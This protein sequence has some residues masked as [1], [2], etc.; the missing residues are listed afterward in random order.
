MSSFRVFLTFVKPYWKLVLVTVVIGMIKFGIPLTMPVL[1]KYVVDDLLLAPLPA[2][3]KTERL[4][5]AM[6]AAFALF[7]VVRAPV[8]YYRQY[9]AQLTTSRILYDMRNK[10]YAHIQKLSLRYYHNHKTGE[11]ISRMINDAEA[12][13]SIVETGMMNVWLDL[14]TLTIAMGFMFYMDAELTLVAIAVLPFYALSVKRMYRKLKA[15][16]KSRSQALAEMQGFV[17]ERVNGMP[18][19]KSFTL[20]RT[21]MDNFDRRNRNFLQRALSL[22]RWNALTNAIINTLTDLSPLLVLLYGGYQVIHGRL[23]MGAFMA[24]FA[25]LDRLFTPLRRIVNS[26]TELTQASASL[27]RVVELMRE[28]YDIQDAPGAVPIRG[29]VPGG[30]EFDRVRFRYDT[31]DRWVLNDLSLTIRPGQTI[32]LVGMSG[33]GKSSLISLIPR[34]YDVQEGAIRLDGRDIRSLTLHS[35]RSQIGMVLQDNILFS[36]SVRDNILFG[37]PSASDE[38]IERAARAANAHD[39]IERLPAGYATEIGERGVKLSGGQKQRIA[40][41]RVFLKNPRIL[42]LDEATSA[43]DLESEH[44]IQESLEQLAKDRTTL[45]VAHRLSTI[46]HADQIV[47]IEDGRIVEQGTHEALM[48]RDGAYARL[49]NVQHLGGAPAQMT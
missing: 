21:E 44:L 27:E 8:E 9:F 18:V 46:T 10:L 15:F 26:S 7:T 33:G 38:E 11:V 34:F 23:T 14:F 13:K 25:Y 48:R 24:F 1:M 6:L 36:G 20:E 37:N 3:V 35:L 29:D 12:T 22:T 30:I 42:I 32:A 47:M 28:P 16:A 45:I 43:L 17:F 4:V 41:A 2:A 40:I 39:F 49:F 5:Y 19:I 31:S